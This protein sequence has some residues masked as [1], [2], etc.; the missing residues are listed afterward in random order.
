MNLSFRAMREEDL[1]DVIK[2]ESACFSDPWLKELFEMELQHDAYAAYQNGQLAG[3]I[4]AMQVLDECSI[5]NIAVQPELHR[6]GV[7]EYMF[8]QLYR[9][10]DKREVRYYYLEVRSSNQAAVALY[11][12]LGFD[13]VGIRKGYYH[14]PI[15]DALVMALNRSQN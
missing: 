2:I 13:R 4:C 9:I 11:E 6:Q 10:M 8:E 7:A 3:Y 5:T 15:E 12:K 14:N 1:E